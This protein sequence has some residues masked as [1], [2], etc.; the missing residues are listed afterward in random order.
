MPQQGDIDANTA[1]PIK[2]LSLKESTQKQ[3]K[4]ESILPSDQDIG[5]N[6]ITS[7]DKVKCYET[8]KRERHE[9]RTSID[10]TQ[11]PFPENPTRFNHVK[12]HY[13]EVI[14]RYR[15]A[16]GDISI[17]QVAR[18]LNVPASVIYAME[19]ADRHF[20]YDDS[21]IYGH[22]KSYSRLL[23]FDYDWA[24]KGFCFHSGMTT[25]PVT[26]IAPS[27]TCVKEQINQSST[28]SPLKNVHF[29]M[30]GESTG[31]ISKFFESAWSIAF[32]LTAAIA[33]A[34][35]FGV[36]QLINEHPNQA[37][38]DAAIVGALVNGQS[39]QSS[40]SSQS[41]VG[42]SPNASSDVTQFG[43]QLSQGVV[44]QNEPISLYAQADTWLQIEQQDG[45]IIF[46]QYLEKDSSFTVSDPSKIHYVRTVNAGDLFFVIG[47]KKLGPVG[48]NRTLNDAIPLHAEYLIRTFNN[49]LQ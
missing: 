48:V 20:F 9:I 35:S 27:S 47:D 45:T 17:Y 16:M 22:L 2:V 10:Y 6:F 46:E 44:R 23:N 39:L 29:L 12:V 24:V 5:G 8:P 19:S 1:V 28:N 41:L 34:V 11:P 36:Y 14:R 13:G 3:T 40:R 38:Q 32:G 15:F 4:V 26:R 7:H 21:L 37:V 49:H 18:E 43:L 31:V 25:A 42:S 33:V 30:N